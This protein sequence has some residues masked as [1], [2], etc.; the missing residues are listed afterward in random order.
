MNT[1]TTKTVETHRSLMIQDAYHYAQ[2][3]LGY[4][5]ERGDET[6]NA[7][8]DLLGRSVRAAIEADPLA[9]FTLIA[10]DCRSKVSVQEAALRLL[11]QI[12]VWTKDGKDVNPDVGNETITE[13]VVTLDDEESILLRAVSTYR[14]ICGTSWSPRVASWGEENQTQ[15]A[16]AS[17]LIRR[18]FLVRVSGGNGHR[19]D[20]T[21]SGRAVVGGGS[22]LARLS[23]SVVSL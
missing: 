3:V 9:G 10:G 13:T 5:A 14:D 20:I 8:R 23:V 12:R 21:D 22:S 19:Y 11:G 1:T 6:F 4:E 17:R 2:R 16:T 18:G 7:K 15:I